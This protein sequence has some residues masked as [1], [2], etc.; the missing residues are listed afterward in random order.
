MTRAALI[1]LLILVILAFIL[2][3]PEFFKLYRVSRV[4]FICL[5]YQPCEQGNWMRMGQHEKRDAEVRRED[6]GMCHPSQTPGS[7]KLE[8]ACTQ[9]C[10]GNMTDPGLDS[11]NGNNNQGMSWF[12]CKTDRDMTRFHINNLLSDLKLYLEVSVELQLG[13]AHT[14]NL[15]LYGLSNHSSL[16]LHLPEQENEEEEEDVK[17]Q[18]EALYCCFTTLPTSESTNHS[19]CLL[20][21][22]N[23]TVLTATAKE[24]LPWKRTGKDEWR[25][26]FKILWLAL[27]CVVLLTIATTVLGQIYWRKCCKKPNVCSVSYNFTGQQLNVGEKHTEITTTKEMMLHTFAP[28]CWPGLSPIEEDETPDV[29]DSLLDENVDHQ[30]YD[31]TGGFNAHLHHHG[32]P[33][34]SFLTEEQD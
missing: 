30:S 9:G 23:Q 34:T 6:T 2:C 7:E 16:Y 8:P 26:M 10:L 11:M 25:C 21:L 19:C 20:W 31:I 29:S 14:L 3:L 13:D 18:K 22:A 17:G 32:H 12:M 27:V 5:P 28:R 1:K 33:S 15:T 4:Q 24:K